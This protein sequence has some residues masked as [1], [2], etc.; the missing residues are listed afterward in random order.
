LIKLLLISTIG[1]PPFEQV[2]AEIAAFLEP[3]RRVGFISAANLFDETEYLRVATERLTR[4]SPGLAEVAHIR[5]DG[6]GLKVLER[7]DAVFVGGGNSYALL[8]R[9]SESRL[10]DALRDKVRGGMSYMGSSAGSNIAGPTILT[11][12][13]WNVVGLTRFEAMA[14][15]PFN[16]NP[17]YVEK[18]AADAANS[19]TRSHRIRE[20]HKVWTNPVVG[21]EEGAVLKVVDRKVTLAGSARAKVFTREGEP[22]WF[23]PGEDLF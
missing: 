23:S 17:H 15:V 7:V 2:L 11:T 4:A 1:S 19:E 3:V 12:N 8:K 14:L 22:R 13:D 10:L 6:D 18:T 5:W 20:Y 9:L 21:I 16:I